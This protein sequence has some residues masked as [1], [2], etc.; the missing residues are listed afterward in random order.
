MAFL[1]PD[2]LSV[3]Y[4]SLVPVVANIEVHNAE[5]AHHRIT[6]VFVL[7]LSLCRSRHQP[8]MRGECGVAQRRW[9]WPDAVP[10]LASGDGQYVGFS[11]K[12]GMSGRTQRVRA[13]RCR[14]GA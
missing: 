14:D 7:P 1:V 10:T 8:E 2:N 11:G 6:R 5:E 4:N 12:C 3:P 9:K 13:R